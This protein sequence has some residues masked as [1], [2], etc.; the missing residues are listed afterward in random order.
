MSVE[1]GLWLD[2]S[3]RKNCSY[4]EFLQSLLFI[5]QDFQINSINNKRT[6]RTFKELISNRSQTRIC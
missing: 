1:R 6:K 4:H 2:V 3:H 5:K